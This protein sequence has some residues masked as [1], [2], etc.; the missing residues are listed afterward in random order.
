MYVVQQFELGVRGL[1]FREHFFFRREEGGGAS[2][3]RKL[4]CSP[5]TKY[6]NVALLTL[7]SEHYLGAV[8]AK[9]CVR[10]FLACVNKKRAAVSEQLHVISSVERAAGHARRFL[11][12]ADLPP[13]TRIDHDSRY[14][15]SHHDAQTQPIGTSS[16]LY[17][18]QY[19]MQHFRRSVLLLLL[20]RPHK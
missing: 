17:R 3:R 14:C 8:R 6:L 19:P 9:F 15:H 1:G 11:M 7:R 13:T 20:S 18:R 5:S 4:V 16:E 2:F 12:I 10:T